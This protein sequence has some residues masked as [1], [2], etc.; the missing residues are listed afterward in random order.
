MDKKVGKAQLTTRET[1][2][3]NRGRESSTEA[4]LGTLRTVATTTCDMTS[5]CLLRVP[6]LGLAVP[7]YVFIVH[8]NEP[9]L[10][11]SFA[12]RV[13]QRVLSVP[14][15]QG[16]RISIP[17]AGCSRRK[18]CAKVRYTLVSAL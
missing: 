9:L 1:G 2:K 15:P 3:K 11:A 10:R 5:P 14:N 8:G 17:G 18:D 16:P 12:D 7:V 4:S 6:S 13:H